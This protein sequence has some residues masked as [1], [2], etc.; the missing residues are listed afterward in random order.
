MTQADM[1]KIPIFGQTY[2]SAPKDPNKCPYCKGCGF[3]LVYYKVPELYGE[4]AAPVEYAVPCRKC[5]GKRSSF[6][7][8]T[9]SRLNLP[10]DAFLSAFNPSLYRDA[11]GKPIDF[12][13][14]FKFIR[15][16]VEKFRKIQSESD[17]KG[18]YISSSTGGTG[19]TFLASIVCNEIYNRYQIMPVYVTENTLL[20]ELERQVSPTAMRPRD[21]YMQAQVLF[22]DDLWRKRTGRDWVTDELFGII[23][24]RYTHELCTIITSNLDLTSP[25]IDTRIASRL[26]EMCASLKMPEMEVRNMNKSENKKKLM[27]IIGEESK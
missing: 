20:N 17:I 25:K 4:D 1:E 26:H 22:I 5:E 24:Y 7:E 10:Y 27:D 6:K 9:K 18:L 19:K 16:F 8:E 3:E 2:K 11:E 13:Q 21:V 15:G 23:D 12:S 14:Q